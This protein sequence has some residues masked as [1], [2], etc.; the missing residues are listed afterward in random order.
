MLQRSPTLRRRRCPARD[1]IADVAAPR[2]AGEASPTRSCAGRTSLQATVFFQLSRRA[3]RARRRRM[4]RKGV[5]AQ[6]PDGLRRRH[7]LHADATTR[8][9][10]ALCLVPDGDLFHGDPRRAARRSS[11][12][13]IETFTETGRAAALGR[14]ARGRH[15][16]HRDRPEPARARRHAAR[17]RRRDGR[18]CP[19]PSAYKGM[20]LSGVPNFAIAR[21]LHERLVDAEVRP[22]RA[23]TSCRLLNHMDAARLRGCARRA[24]P[25][26]SAPR[27]RSST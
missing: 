19:R 14:R 21:R 23:S 5:A 13:R 11:P 7:A 26:P 9:T 18:R 22:R 16:R 2:A 17:R 3:P 10:S 15:R 20:M 25:T 8:G 27:S 6:L 24:S 4:L 12:T 1:P